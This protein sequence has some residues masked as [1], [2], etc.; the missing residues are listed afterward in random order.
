VSSRILR[1]KD[2]MAKLGIGRTKF[3]EDIRK[4][5]LPPLVRLGPRAVGHIEAELDSYIDRL[6][7]DVGRNVGKSEEN[8]KSQVISG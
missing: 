4:G 1:P 8:R 5:T 3:Y 6:R 2:A 7:S